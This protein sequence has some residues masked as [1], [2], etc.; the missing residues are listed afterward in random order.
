MT[1]CKQHVFYIQQPKI[2]RSHS[3]GYR[4]LQNKRRDRPTI[5]TLK[6]KSGMERGISVTSLERKM[7][8]Q[9]G[10]NER[11]ENFPG[12]VFH[13]YIYRREDVM[14]RIHSHL[15]S[16]RR[17]S[18]QVPNLRTSK[19][20]LYRRFQGKVLTGKRVCDRSVGLQRVFSVLEKR[21]RDM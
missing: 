6:T 17:R 20:Y 3:R 4:G 11:G 9:N 16:G 21:K 10:K 7:R 8:L 15:R 14:P 1:S 12:L 2:T 19:D 13:E 18:L 5:R